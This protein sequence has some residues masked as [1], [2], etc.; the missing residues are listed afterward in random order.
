MMEILVS[1]FGRARIIVDECTS[2]IRNMKEIKNDTDFIDFV[3]HIDKLKRDLEQLNLLSDIANTTVIADLEEK[4]P[5][6]VKRDWVK[7]VSSKELASEPPSQI[8]NK[9]LEFLE[10]TKLQAE[11]LKTEVRSINTHGRVNPRVDFVC[12]VFS[13]TQPSKFAN[14]PT[15][16]KSR[17]CLACADELTDLESSMH[18]TG[19]CAVWCNLSLQEKTK[20][21]NCVQCPF[22]GKE[23]RHTTAECKKTKF[24]CHNCLEENDHHT[25][26]CTKPN[27][28]LCKV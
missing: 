7:L 11:Y 16:Q 25:W 13:S 1:K 20:K 27:S 17:P 21:V 3:E 14:E 2:E 12:G 23:T 24:K 19:N 26:F 10:E 18:P 4:L 22:G 8:F 6:E 5:Y 28:R 15:W 9:L